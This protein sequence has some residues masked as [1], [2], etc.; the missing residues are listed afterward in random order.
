MSKIKAIVVA[1]EYD[2]WTG[3]PRVALAPY[4]EKSDAFIDKLWCRKYTM[5]DVRNSTRLDR[6]AYSTTR[7]RP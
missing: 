7:A 4:D 6:G 3:Y 5:R 2:S 1:D